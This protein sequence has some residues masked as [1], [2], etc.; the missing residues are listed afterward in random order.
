MFADTGP[1][2]K[3]RQAGEAYLF[4]KIPKRTLRVAP[5]DILSTLHDFERRI[6]NKRHNLT[7]ITPEMIIKEIKLI[8][9]GPEDDTP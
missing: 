9:L 1:S 5:E 6:E 7:V 4:G 3:E 2:L 8:L